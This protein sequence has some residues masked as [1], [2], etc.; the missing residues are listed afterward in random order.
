MPITENLGNKVARS[1]NKG[2]WQSLAKKT[3]SDLLPHVVKFFDSKRISLKMKQDIFYKYNI[4]RTG[5]STTK[6]KKKVMDTYAYIRD[7]I[8]QNLY[9]GVN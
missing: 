3:Y 7:T 9:S 8:N 4:Q 5:I 6:N 2:S 1:N